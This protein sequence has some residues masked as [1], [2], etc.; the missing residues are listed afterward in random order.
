MGSYLSLVWL[1][2]KNSNVVSSMHNLLFR[3][4]LVCFG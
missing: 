2:K 1:N 4:V 3:D